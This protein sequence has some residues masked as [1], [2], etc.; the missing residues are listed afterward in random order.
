METVIVERTL[1][2][3]ANAGVLAD[4]RERMVSCLQAHN[5]R[6]VQSYVSADGQRMICVYQAPDAESVRIAL[7][8]HGV[9]PFDQAWKASVW[10]AE[11]IAALAEAGTARDAAS[12]STLSPPR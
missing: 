1:D 4:N 9:L 8:Q 10:R 12:Q 11:D 2:Q 6:F 5:V 7:R 3:P